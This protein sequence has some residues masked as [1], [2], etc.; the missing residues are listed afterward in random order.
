MAGDAQPLHGQVGGLPALRADGRVQKHLAL[1]ACDSFDF[2]GRIGGAG[3]VHAAEVFTQMKTIALSRLQF[4]GEMTFLPSEPRI[5]PPAGPVR[6]NHDSIGE[7]SRFAPGG[8]TDGEAFTPS[9]SRGDLAT[10]TFDPGALS[11]KRA[12][13][14]QNRESDDEDQRSM[15]EAHA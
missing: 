14:Q 1:R 15:P 3:L 5:L 6:L 4:P 11:D 8:G 2:D 12:G 10:I 7:W 9:F 13:R